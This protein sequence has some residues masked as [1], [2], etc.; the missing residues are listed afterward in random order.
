MHVGF[1][2][3]AVGKHSS[4]AFYRVTHA[5]KRLTRHGKQAAGG[6]IRFHPLGK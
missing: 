2:G 1:P 6:G 4:G 3:D 5:R